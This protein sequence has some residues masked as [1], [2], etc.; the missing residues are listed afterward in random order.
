[1]HA[2]SGPRVIVAALACAVACVIQAQTTASFTQRTFVGK[3]FFLAYLLNTPHWVSVEALTVVGGQKTISGAEA[4]GQ[5]LDQPDS[6]D[7]PSVEEVFA[8]LKQAQEA[9]CRR[10]AMTYDA[11]DGHPVW[12]VIERLIAVYPGKAT[13]EFR[14][15]NLT[16]LPDGNGS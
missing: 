16:Y 7:F 12:C 8:A 2:S 9:G 13:D 10:V 14:I 15:R 4:D 1:M 5:P 11:A 3:D 6:L